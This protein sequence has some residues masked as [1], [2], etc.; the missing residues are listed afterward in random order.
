MTPKEMAVFMWEEYNKIIVEGLGI[1][2]NE[3][4]WSV[5][6]ACTMLALADLYT[7]AS[8][9]SSTTGRQRLTDKEWWKAIID[10]LAS[11]KNIHDL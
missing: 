10:E 4:S 9:I 7:E 3:A 1:E 8:N 11:L 2:S 6:K 5:S